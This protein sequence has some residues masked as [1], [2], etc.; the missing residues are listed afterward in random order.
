MPAR[1]ADSRAFCSVLSPRSRDGGLGHGLKM[2]RP[3]ELQTR[4]FR[5]ISKGLTLVEHSFILSS[6]PAWPSPAAPRT[7]PRGVPWGRPGVDEEHGD[8]AGVERTRRLRSIGPDGSRA[9][10]IAA[11]SSWRTDI[12]SVSGRGSTAR[13]SRRPRAQR[14]G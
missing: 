10:L 13:Q 11:V 1:S 8:D 7:Y 9:A 12:D 6:V 4:T 14:Q 3:C 2:C 5:L